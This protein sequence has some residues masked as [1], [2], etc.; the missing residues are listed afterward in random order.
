[1]NSYNPKGSEKASFL[2]TAE[3][4][5]QTSKNNEQVVHT[6]VLQL[7]VRRAAVIL[8]FLPLFYELKYKV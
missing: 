6:Q 2:L 7:G 4:K 3:T 1:M 8:P 5:L